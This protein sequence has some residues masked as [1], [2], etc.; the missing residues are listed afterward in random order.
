MS[1]GLTLSGMVSSH[2][3]SNFFNIFSPEFDP[4]L[5]ITFASALLPTLAFQQLVF[6][7]LKVIVQLYCEN[8]N[9]IDPFVERQIFSTYKK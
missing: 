1:L 6:P 9:F 4:S 2:R 7:R 5:A 8:L 3:V